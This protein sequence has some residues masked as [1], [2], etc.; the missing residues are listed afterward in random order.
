MKRLPFIPLRDIVMFPGI[1]TSINVGRTISMNTVNKAVAENTRILFSTQKDGNV[2]E[3]DL[4]S[5]IHSVGVIGRI[6]ESKKLKNNTLAVIIEVE[7]RVLIENA[8]IENDIFMADFSVVNIAPV[9]PDN[10]TI[11]ILATKSIE[12][13]G[14]Y[15]GAGA[16]L[17]QEM[18]NFAAKVDNY[19]VF[20]VIAA[21]LMIPVE[22]KQKLLATFDAE[23]RGMAVLT[24]LNR[25]IELVSIE[26]NIDEE[27]K[28]K[29]NNM[30]K[31]FFLKEKINALKDEI[32]EGG[33]SEL[34]ELEAKIKKSK[35]PQN[36]ADKLQSEVNKLSKMPPFS[37]EASVSRTYIDVVLSLPW[38][39]ETKDILDIEKASKVLENDHYGLVDVKDKILDFI[40]VKQF[41]PKVKGQ[42]L[43]LAGPPGVGKTSLGKSIAEAMGRNF[44]RI[45]LGG[46]KDESEIRG[47]RRTYIGSMPGKIIKALKEAGTKNPV[48]LL[49]EIDKMA[50]DMRGDPAS[51]M[52]EV[53][54]P[55]QNNH[56]EDHYLDLPFDLS[57][58]L[59]IATANDLKFISA[60]LRDRME[61]ISLN[62]YTEFEK[63]NIAK[64]HLISR[65][66][67][68]LGITSKYKITIPDDV[69]MKIINEYTRE[70]GVRNLKRQL[71]TLFTKITRE[72]LTEKKNTIKITVTNLEKYL[73]PQKFRPDKMRE[74]VYKLGV[75]NGLAW[76][77]VGG[78]T[79][80]VQAVAVDGKGN[81]VLSVTG[82][83]GDVMKE[84]ST[85]AFSYIKSHLEDLKIAK[86]D[87]FAKK[88][89]HLHFPEG[90]TPKD[91]PSAG[92]AIASALLSVISGRKIRQDVAMTGEIT[93]TGEVLAIGGVKEKVIGGHRVGIREIILPLD[94]KADVIDIPKEIAKDMKFYFVSHYDEVEKIVL[95]KKTASKG[96][97]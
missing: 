6:V 5:G 72:I 19:Q 90:A 10:A 30:Q 58:V 96:K 22:E 2:E 61:I 1:T 52:L 29:L 51:A 40:A 15:L 48:I 78:T 17:P 4:V 70:A 97:K 3:P 12:A 11:R 77:S 41:N 81:S 93:I 79:L 92:I 49:D 84:S 13:L 33:D 9:S 82:S 62:S 60:P 88:D 80:E 21:N 16:K 75:V 47:H 71:N 14:K 63:A 36:V 34:A 57:N 56:F 55:E 26:K 95:E 91:G 45:S 87:F 38:S 66:K 86:T 69:I 74:K 59:F 46:V 8:A 24:V 25:E 31:N 37:A 73:G 83:L 42:I 67:S 89:I 28:A 64:N 18:L 43:C 7:H 68:D 53:L 23:A 94:N 27:V 20:D 50:S 54:D 35:L 44:I 39:K 65:I 85:V 76:T 32:G